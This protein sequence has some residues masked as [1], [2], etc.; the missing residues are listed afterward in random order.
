MQEIE[1][2]LSGVTDQE[3]I[4]RTIE[5]AC[6]AQDLQLTLKGSLQKHPGC[7]HWH[8][9]KPGTSGTLE[10]TYWPSENRCWF[11][12]RDGRAKTWVVEMMNVLKIE[13][14]GQVKK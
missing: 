12:Y 4:E 3:R 1:I 5:A 13:I 8:Y 2:H 6:L 10:I 14:E 9:Q 11:P 7:I